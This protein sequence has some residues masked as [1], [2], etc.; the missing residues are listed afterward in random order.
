[1]QENVDEGGSREAEL[2]EVLSAYAEPRVVSFRFVAAFVLLG[3]LGCASLAWL[4]AG[5]PRH[6]P[7]RFEAAPA[8]GFQRGVGAFRAADWDE[9]LRLM[10]EAQGA[11]D[12]PLPRVEDF[13]DRLE[14][15]RRD[16][17]RLVRVEQ[18]LAANDAA[19]ALGVAG[20]IAPNSPLFAQAEGLSRRARVQLQSS[21]PNEPPAQSQAEGAQAERGERTQRRA[22]A[23]A[24]PARG[25]TQRP[26][27][28][29]AVR[30]AGRRDPSEAW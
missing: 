30:G 13:I 9:A 10:R 12:E 26:R 11:L 7:L 1:M 20:L 15:I 22:R 28:G 17:E 23:S 18:A 25:E 5:A 19:R 8:A 24:T 21:S 14:L 16:E 6:Q 29:R 3:L 2:L 27:D 4:A